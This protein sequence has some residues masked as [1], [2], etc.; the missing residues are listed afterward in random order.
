[1]CAGERNLC[2]ATPSTRHPRKK[3]NTTEHFCCVFLSNLMLRREN[4]PNIRF[5]AES[6]AFLISF[7]GF[8]WFEFKAI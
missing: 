6:A 7:V 2:N 4:Y 1:V 3:V 8:L 5:R